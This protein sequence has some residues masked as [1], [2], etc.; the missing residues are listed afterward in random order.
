M[1]LAMPSHVEGTHL[2]T[3][4][5]SVNVGVRNNLPKVALHLWHGQRP[6]SA[7]SYRLP[8]AGS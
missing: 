2:P 8:T 5:L 1:S 6:N 4:V 7:T 3:H